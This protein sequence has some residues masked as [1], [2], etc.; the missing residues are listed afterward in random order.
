MAQPQGSLDDYQKKGVAGGGVCMCIKT[1][2]IEGCGKKGFGVA[3][4]KH[5]E[6]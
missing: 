1:K 4:T 2:E 6:W 5:N 3:R